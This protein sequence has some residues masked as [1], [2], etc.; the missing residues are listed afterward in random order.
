MTNTGF[1]ISKQRLSHEQIRIHFSKK[2]VRMTINLYR[3]TDKDTK[4][5]V[6]YVPSLEVSGYGETA[7]K[8]ME[9]V[10]ESLRDMCHFLVTLSPEE[11]TVELRKYGWKKGIFN[12]EYSR[13][14]VDEKG[15]LKDLNAD[16]NSVEKMTLELA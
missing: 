11:A 12:K 6:F 1:N 7:K 10:H 3:F 5:F 8:A 16:E 13:M 15:K 4:Q 14:C 2:I 9:M